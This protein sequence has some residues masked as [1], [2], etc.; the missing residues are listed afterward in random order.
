MRPEP[1]FCWP[2]VSVAPLDNDFPARRRGAA[3]RLA[4]TAILVAV[5][6]ELLIAIVP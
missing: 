2:L 3:G 5:A 4:L 6:V 1:C